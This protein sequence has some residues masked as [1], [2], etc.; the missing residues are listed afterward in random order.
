M[1]ITRTPLRISI[2]GGGTD[3][4]SYYQ[5]HG[6]FVISAA[7]N[8]YVYISINRSFT[9]G[10]QLKY[11]SL[12]RVATIDEI[13]HRI[14]REAFRMHDVEP[15]VELVSVADV[16]S[17]TGLGS[18]G[19]FTVGI[20]HALHAHQRRPV[21]AA[22]LAR[23]AVE[24][25]MTRL[26]EPVGKQDH[27]S[28][29]YGGLICQEYSPDGSVR[30]CPLAIHHD[31]ARELREGL[32]LFFTGYSRSAG[33]LLREQDQ[34]SRSGQPLMLDGLHFVKAMGAR[35]KQALESNDVDAFGE[36]LHEHWT[37]KKE[38]SA[39]MSNKW[40]DG[41]Y[42]HGRANGAVGGKLVGAGG[43]GFLL[44][45]TRDRRR[46]RRAMTEHGLQEMEIDF[47]Y[48]GSSVMAR[49]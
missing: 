23:E 38:R 28:A 1:L 40:I 13:Q 18:S 43:G 2:G 25:E 26:G 31:T 47:D 20:L 29:A 44:F 27:Y 5:T 24:I 14:I 19:A 42:E 12:E 37:R 39:G 30:I 7:I 46:L 36:C 16:P 45:Y 11:S 35:I 6:G 48:Q 8:R 9:P 21:D 41:A 4:P 3:L 15:P 34:Q 10:Y 32:M 22:R 17:G 49:D 33:D